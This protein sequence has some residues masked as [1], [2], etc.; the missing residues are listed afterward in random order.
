MDSDRVLAAFDAEVRRNVRPDGSGA[1]IEADPPVVRW[2][3]ADGQGW[4]G[5]AWSGL[6]DAD[7]DAVIAGQV[8]YFAARGEQF[9]WKLYDYDRPPDLGRRLLAAGFAAE[10]EESLMV[11]E[12]SSAPT[13]VDLP[14][15]AA[16]TCTSTLPR[17]AS[18]SWPVSGS[19]AS[20]LPLPMSGIPAASRSSRRNSARR[21][22]G[23]ERRRHALGEMPVQARRGTDR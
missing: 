1:R 19:A 17:I 13:Q 5:I 7:A 11:T 21:L 2:V 22:A 12:V 4:S 6:G 20:P 8:A 3:G 23:R 15:G 9:E 16:V 18:R 14:P 10:G